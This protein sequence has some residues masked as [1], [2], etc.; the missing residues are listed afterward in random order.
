MVRKRLYILLLPIIYS[1]QAC[2]SPVSPDQLI[3]SWQTDSI[4]T[5]YNGF[6]DSRKAGGY[7][8]M[9]TYKPNGIIR[10]SR[11]TDFREFIYQ[12][13]EPDTLTYQSADGRQIGTYQVLKLG[14]NELILK[15][16]KGPIF[17]GKG[18]ERYEV[19]FFSKVQ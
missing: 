12:W 9:F 1:L 7:E 18:Q 13:K 19:R 4:Y 2:Q 17:E 6:Q 3:G 10:E 8:S 16:Q 5:Y 15:K 11:G 14:K